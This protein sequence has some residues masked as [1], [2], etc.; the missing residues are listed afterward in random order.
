M[1]SVNSLGD[2][3][4]IF[5]PEPINDQ[6][7]K[8]GDVYYIAA[9]QSEKDGCVQQGGRPGIVI[10]NNTGNQHSPV[11]IIVYTTTQRK[12][13]FPTHVAIRSLPEVSTALCEQI[14]TVSKS[15]LCEFMGRLTEEEMKGVDNAL[16]ASI[17]LNQNQQPKEIEGITFFE[18]G[19]DKL[20]QE[21]QKKVIC[22]S[23]TAKRINRTNSA[24]K[25]VVKSEG[26]CFM[27]SDLIELDSILFPDDLREIKTTAIN[28][29][30]KRKKADEDKLKE[31]I[32]GFSLVPES[33]PDKQH[34]SNINTKPTL[35]IKRLTVNVKK[36]VGQLY[37]AGKEMEEIELETGIDI[38]RISRYIKESGLGDERYKDESIPSGGSA[39]IPTVGAFRK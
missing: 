7:I 38:V 4:K 15:R 27:G 16:R 39:M 6:E 28:Q 21:A 11:A 9:F 23:E 25:A 2:I 33:A 36:Q 30:K 29:I 17:A 24:L 10:G 35:P 31:L 13:S 8:R 37:K 20:L 22:I 1:N 18:C 12:S 32:G 26:F 3:G 19:E 5:P 14:I 34:I